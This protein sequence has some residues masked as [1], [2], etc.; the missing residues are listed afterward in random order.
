MDQ[1]EAVKE[2]TAAGC[3]V[4]KDAADRLDDHRVE[5][6]KELSPSPMVVNERLIDNLEAGEI[7]LETSVDVMTDIEREKEKRD[8][9][10]FVN[11][12]NDRYERLKQLLLRRR[13]VQN[14]VSISRLDDMAERDEV[15][16][17]GMVKDKYRTSSGKFI[18]YLEDPTGETK[19]L[20][21]PD[22]GEQIVLDEVIAA[23]G[24]LGDDIVFADR[25]IWPDVPLP[26]DV[27]SA[28]EEV[29]AA[30]ISDI[31]FGSID[32][33]NDKLDAFLDWLERG[34]DE[35]RKVRYL[36]IVGDAVEGVGTYPGQEAEL[37]V[38]NIY[39]QYERFQE[40]VKDIRDDIE[41]IIAP[42][43]HDMV[44]LAEPQPPLPEDAV[45]ELYEMDNVHLVPNP[46][47]VKVHG[48]AGDGVKVLLYHGY[49]FDGHVD[50]LPHLRETAYENP[51]NAMIDWL[52][53][54]HLAPIYGS[55]LVVPD[56]ED[57]LVIDT[58]P[59]II[60]AGHAHAFGCTTYKGINVVCAGTFQGQTAFQERMGHE[61]Q[62]GKVAVVNLESRETVVKQF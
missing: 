45:P 47:Y 50:A 33:L 42:G 53:R 23:N 49:S 28:S 9:N 60:A 46:A 29:Y 17:V 32:T 39:K 12:Y 24:S 18:V 10:D 57:P 11:F 2:L 52:K 56:E 44:R 58:L 13:E 38:T 20:A 8:V 14:A 22:E 48:H 5:R 41:V 30:F 1:Q 19:I 25:I 35:A 61:P 7:S 40:F 51:E 31:H 62:P 26:S 16:V 37:E 34:D 59:D 4:Q 21:Y 36:F 27:P 6:I 54:R 55:N 3:I 43:N 15:S